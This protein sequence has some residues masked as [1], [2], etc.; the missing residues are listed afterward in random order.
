MM[1]VQMDNPRDDGCTYREG[2]P[3]LSRIASLGLVGPKKNLF[4]IEE[5]F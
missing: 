1:L 5:V 3:N 4:E 2:N